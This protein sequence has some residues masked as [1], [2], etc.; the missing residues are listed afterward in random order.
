[1]TRNGRR[2]GVEL[3]LISIITPAYNVA[4]TLRRA[5]A[6]VRDQSYSGWEIVIV[7]DGSTDETPFVLND[8][9]QDPR[10]SATV[11]PNGGTGSALNVGLQRG[12]GSY[13]AFLDAD[14]EFLP[15]HLRSHIVAMNDDPQIDLFWGGMEVIADSN[16]DTLVPD[17]ENG[18]ALI[19]VCGCIVQGTLFGR[20]NVFSD[21]RFSEDRSIWYQDYEFVQRVRTKYNVH[22]FERPTY[23]YYRNSG[24]STVD[25][26]K[27]E[28]P[29]LLS[30][31][32][33]DAIW[34]L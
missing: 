31:P 13:I 10:V 4:N 20:R 17:V 32:G 23:R 25:R 21:F 19:P 9:L 34:S 16:E 3:E 7:D 6:S 33:T 28:C 2:S 29:E 5:Y 27:A 30:A 14:D 22:Q 1:M 24:R 8:L 18:N 12:L 11:V 26:I 15:D